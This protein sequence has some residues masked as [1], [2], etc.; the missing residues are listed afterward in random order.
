MR[1][2]VSVSLIVAFLFAMVTLPVG[3]GGV[4]TEAGG[5]SAPRVIA[6]QQ[7]TTRR[8]SKRRPT[9]HFASVMR[10][11][12]VKNFYKELERAERSANGTALKMQKQ[13]SSPGLVTTRRY[14]GRLQTGCIGGCFR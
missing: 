7:N 11:K 5:V 12:A 14:S 2:V 9:S 3:A 13:P 10:L 1:A 4:S 6:A 8:L